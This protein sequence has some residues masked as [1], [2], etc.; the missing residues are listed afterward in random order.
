MVEPN[1]SN[2][3]LYFE[4]WSTG[5]TNGWEDLRLESDFSDYEN[6]RKARTIDDNID[7][8]EGSSRTNYNYSEKNP[9]MRY[10]VCNFTLNSTSFGR[11]GVSGEDINNT[12]D[13]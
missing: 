6:Y 4:L 13:S 12:F 2:E 9:A 10:S 8:Y 11:K 5:K 1:V 7:L 3:N